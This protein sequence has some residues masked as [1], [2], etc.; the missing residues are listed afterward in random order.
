M[1]HG[2]R[3]LSSHHRRRRETHRLP[4]LQRGK[5]DIVIRRWNDI[6]AAKRPFLVSPDRS[7]A[8]PFPAYSLFSVA[9]MP[10]NQSIFTSAAKNCLMS[11][12][13][14]ADV[15][16]AA[17]VEPAAVPLACADLLIYSYNVLYRLW[18]AQ[19]QST[20]SDLH[21]TLRRYRNVLHCTMQ[22]V[23]AFRSAEQFQLLEHIFEPGRCICAEGPQVLYTCISPQHHA[24]LLSAGSRKLE[25]LLLSIDILLQEVIERQGGLHKLY[26]TIHKNTW[27]VGM[28]DLVPAGPASVYNLT[29]WIPVLHT[30]TLERKPITSGS[31]AS[32]LLQCPITPKPGF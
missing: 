1:S 17:L 25:C 16:I 4:Y 21:H 13:D 24:T 14:A 20:A 29:R 23:C 8:L 3:T 5:A 28:G 12:D 9:N 26:R 22:F 30:H 15:I 19:E 2:W 11:P 10:I 27:P 18:R 32:Y 7:G 6:T 31:H